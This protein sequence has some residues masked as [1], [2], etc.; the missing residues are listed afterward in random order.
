MRLKGKDIE[1]LI[2][3]RYPMVMVDEFEATAENVAQTALLVRADNL[4]MLADG[5]LSETGLIEH[6]AQSAAA[7]AGY[8]SASNG[9][10]R[11]GLIGEVKHFECHRRPMAS[12]VVHTTI[13][14]GFSFGSVTL[15][16]GHCRIGDEEIASAN[17]KIF[18][19]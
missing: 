11:I 15:V 14:F 4:F 17:L 3:Q 1:R 13:E 9:Q 2:P 6:V 18:M 5:T 7:L 12:E 19:Q 8:Q 16:L 10:P